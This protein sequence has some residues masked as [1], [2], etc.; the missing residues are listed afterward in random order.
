MSEARREAEA[1]VLL[2][3]VDVEL[4][5]ENTKGRFRS[6]KV[7]LLNPSVY[8][9]MSSNLDSFLENLVEKPYITKWISYYKMDIIFVISDYKNIINHVF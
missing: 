3:F 7:S 5:V 6:E 2:G 8:G 9:L 1:M 4:M